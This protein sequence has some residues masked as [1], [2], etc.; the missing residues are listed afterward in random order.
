MTGVVENTVTLS[1][2]DALRAQFYR[3]LARL[4]SAPAD[5]AVLDQLAGLDGDDTP[6]GR[7]LSALGEAARDVSLDDAEDEFNRLFIGMTRG[8]LVP[9]GSFYVTGFLNEKPLADLRA[10]MAKLG[11]ARAEGVSEP[12]DHIAALAEMMAG[13]IEGDFGVPETVC[14]QKAFFEKHL[15]PWAGRF[16]ADLEGART[17]ALFRPVGA[18]GRVF[19]EIEAE[20]FSMVG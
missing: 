12:E 2:E 7:A 14:A 18:A 5:Q 10:D 3:F 15:A 8:E 17:A 11:I 4:L 1:E 6:L 20:G 16:F 9:F 13:L 19:M